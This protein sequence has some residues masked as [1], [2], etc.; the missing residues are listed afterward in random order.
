M[1]NCIHWNYK[2]YKKEIKYISFKL[3]KTHS[4]L[5]EKR[6]GFSIARINSF[7]EVTTSIKNHIESFKSKKSH[8][9]RQDTGRSYLQPDLSV[10]VMWK[11]WKKKREIYKKSIASLSKYYNVFCINF[12]LA[13]VHPRQD[14]CSFC[15]ETSVNLFTAKFFFSKIFISAELFFFFMFLID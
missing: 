12:N 8:Y 11:H 3:K 5:K 15:S 1:F 6:G 2:N 7:D 4:S 10:S 14:V 9:C 13:F